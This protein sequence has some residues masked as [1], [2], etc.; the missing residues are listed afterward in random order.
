VEDTM[1]NKQPLQQPDIDLNK[2]DKI[3]N[4]YNADKELLISSFL[5]HSAWY[6]KVS[7]L[8]MYAWELHVMSELQKMLY[9]EL[10]QTLE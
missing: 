2:I 4:D 1:S 5:R 7:I 8:S 3:I 10:K 6:P 9:K